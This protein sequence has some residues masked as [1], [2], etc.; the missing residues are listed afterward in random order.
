MMKTPPAPQVPPQPVAAPPLQPVGQ[1]PQAKASQPTFLG[2]LQQD[3]Q[4][5]QQGTKTLLGA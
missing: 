1:K 2:G 3:A 5:Q 4:S